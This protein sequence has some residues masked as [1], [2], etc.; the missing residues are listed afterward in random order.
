MAFFGGG[1][2]PQSAFGG[3]TSQGGL[4]GQ[5]QPPTSGFG[6]QQPQGFGGQ[7]Q[8]MAPPD[9]SQCCDNLDVPVQCQLSDS[10]ATLKFSPFPQQGSPYMQVGFRMLAATT[11]DGQLLIFQVNH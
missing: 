1:Q 10:V 9:Y 3:A 5:Q 4:F 8:Q 11:W 7:Q 2:Q 6:Q